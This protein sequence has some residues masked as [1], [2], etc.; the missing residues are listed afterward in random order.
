MALKR[1]YTATFENVTIGTAVQDIFYVKA[2]T[3]NLIELHSIILTAGQAITTPAEIRVRL[4]KG[5]GTV[6]AGSA[7]SALTG[8]PAD[9]FDPAALSTARSNDTTQATAT[10]FLTLGAWQWNELLP[11]ELLWPADDR[12]QCKPSEGFVLDFPA[13]IAAAVSVSGVLTWAE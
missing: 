9:S 6:T 11:F 2:G 13:A 3:T 1:V 5:T 4:K 8:Q 10:A 12:P 7:G